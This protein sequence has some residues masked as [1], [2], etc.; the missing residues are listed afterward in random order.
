M[1]LERTAVDVRGTT[2]SM[3]RTPVDGPVVVCLHGIPSSAELWRDVLG[4][5]SDGGWQAIAPDL[6]GYGE[7]ISPDDEELS[8]EASTNVIATWLATMDEP[9][10]I[11]GH[12]LGG[13]VAQHLATQHPE[14]VSRLSLVNS[15]HADNWPVTPVKVMRALAKAGMLARLLRSPLAPDPYTKRSLRRAVADPDVL[16]SGTA[17]RVFTSLGELSPR[18][19][20]AF[21]RHVG[22]LDPGP[23]IVTAG[24]LR[25]LTVPTQLVWG[26][27]DPYQPWEPNGQR[28]AALLS[29]PRIDLMEDAGHFVQLDAPRRL[30][31]HLLDF[32]G[33]ASG[34][35]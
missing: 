21:Q 11:V 29:E 8:L 24:Q 28:L 34:Q 6:L 19:A 4:V 12:D 22:S 13:I 30:A 23:A 9:A 5:L 27:Q 14:L 16:G 1:A 7:T 18:N 17:E 2:L 33:P 25:N 15:P 26:L 10:W 35:D 31:E 32:A 20:R 3:L